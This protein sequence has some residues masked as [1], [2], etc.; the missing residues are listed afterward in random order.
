MLENLKLGEAYDGLLFLAEATRNPPVLRPH[1]HAELELNLV[2]E[3]EVTSVVAGRRY[4]FP[5]RSLLWL[6]PSQE[7]QLVHRSADAA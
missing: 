5:K 2:A 1:H 4:C 6:F 7:H 3:G